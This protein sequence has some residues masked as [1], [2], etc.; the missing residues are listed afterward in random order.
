MTTTEPTPPG[1]LRPITLRP[2]TRRR[3]LQHLAAGAAAL[4]SGH[5]LAQ[6]DKS[7]ITVLVGAASSMDFCARLIADQLREALG[8][9]AIVLS[10]LGAGQRIAMQECRR[11][12]PDGRT[13]VFA[14]SGPFA[15]YPHIYNKLD[16]DPVA[17]FTPIIGVSA[18]DVAVS[19]GPMTG[20]TTLKQ[21]IDWQRAKKPGDALFAS[22]PG[23]GSLS[24]FL[25]ISI[26]L[27]TNIDLTHVPYKDS[28]VGMIDLSASRLPM[29]ITGLSPQIEM[30]KAGKTRLLAVS[31]DT[32][33]PLVPEV[34][35]LKEAGVNVSSTTFTGV[36]GPAKM[37]PE[38]VKRIYDAIL[39][40]LS[41]TTVRDR[42]AAQAMSMMPATGPQLAGALVD[43]RKRFEVLVKAS[44]MVKEDA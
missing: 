24:H 34:P 13:L 8:R 18:F 41:N 2:V 26:G 7:A 5:V 37:P 21:L 28:G 38:I 6:D 36:F 10:K 40:M 23:N 9:P 25:G 42:L 3:S 17:D 39:P 16:Y 35:T 20:A 1:T 32:R 43:E 4:A 19:T 11:A 15:I 29:L 22:A 27:A 30:H 14:T 33:S 31:G 12:A 44:G